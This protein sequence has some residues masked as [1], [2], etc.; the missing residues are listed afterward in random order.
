MTERLISVGLPVYNGG[1]QLRRAIDH[2][3]AQTHRNLEILIS[4][5]ASTDGITAQVIEEYAARD[6]RIRVF[7]QSTN[8]GACPNFL[9]VLNE[10]RG[11]YF[12]WAAHDDEHDPG[13]IAALAKGLDAQEAAVLAAPKTLV[14][15]TLRDGKF[16]EYEI[17]C[18]D[19]T[20]RW[21]LID[22]FIQHHACVWIYGL[23]RTEWLK[24]RAAEML[25]YH[26]EVADRIWLFGLM[27]EHPIAAC[28]D[29]TLTYADAHA[30]RPKS[31]RYRMTTAHISAYFLCRQAFRRL[32]WRDRPRGLYYAAK[33]LHRFY[34][35]RGNPISTVVHACKITLFSVLFGLESV[36]QWLWQRIVARP[37]TQQ[38]SS[39]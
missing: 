29:A 20:D 33:L 22:H 21:Q 23:F 9:Y 25:D 3:L 36:A 4:N 12:L 7:H 8:I 34:L 15:K 1:H 11:D 5:N 24:T 35:T 19:T 6:S 10:A 30:K 16:R 32:P 18:C 14:R 17:P 27:L 38:V 28:P 2:L 39:S 13:F 31:F 37:K 26:L